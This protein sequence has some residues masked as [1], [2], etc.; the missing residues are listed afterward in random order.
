[1]IYEY[2]GYDQDF[3]NEIGR[4]TTMSPQEKEAYYAAREEKEK[5][6]E[7]VRKREEAEQAARFVAK[8]LIRMGYPVTSITRGIITIDLNDG[9]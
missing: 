5:A 3:V 2:R 4:L 1:M 9:K 6:R 8:R 7:Q